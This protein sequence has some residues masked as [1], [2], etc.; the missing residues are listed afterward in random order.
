VAR[1]K[2]FETEV[3]VEMAFGHGYAVV[4][5]FALAGEHEWFGLELPLQGLHIEAPQIPACPNDVGAVV[6]DVLRG[7]RRHFG[8]TECAFLQ[9]P[10]VHG[11]LRG[12]N[13]LHA[14]LLEAAFAIGEWGG[15]QETRKFRDHGLLGKVARPDT[16]VGSVGHG[17]RRLKLYRAGSLLGDEGEGFL[18]PQTAF[19]MTCFLR[20]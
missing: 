4:V 15:G 17:G 14:E 16:H 6:V 19:G 9:I 10:F 20:A 11:Y 18:T 1:K 7:E 13:R 12:I 2:V 8:R 3:G 5:G